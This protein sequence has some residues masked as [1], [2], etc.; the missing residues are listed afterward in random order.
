MHVERHPP[1]IVVG[2]DQFQRLEQ[3][4]AMVPM[5]VGKHDTFDGTEID[6]QSRAI[7]LYGI[8]L[9][10]AIEQERMPYAVGTGGD[11]ERQT[12]MGA[13]DSLAAPFSHAGSYQAYPL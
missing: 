6:A 13:A 12:E 1:T 9:R 8:T 7:A 5:A 2:P 10:T 4:A 3:P 11:D